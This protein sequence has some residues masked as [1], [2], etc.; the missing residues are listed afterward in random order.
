[1]LA[2][3]L[4]K[5]AA[6]ESPYAVYLDIDYIETLI[7]DYSTDPTKCLFVDDYGFIAGMLS[8]GHVFYPGITVALEIAWYVLPEHRGKMVGGRLYKQ[9][10]EWAISNQARIIF[11]G[12]QVKG[13]TLV[14]SGYMKWV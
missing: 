14:Q 6:K 7:Q 1:M 10:E 5:E 12:R 11:V 8:K 4:I 13:S 2:C 3:N 9:F